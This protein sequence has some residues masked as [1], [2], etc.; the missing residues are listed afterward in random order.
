LAPKWISNRRLCAGII[1]QAIGG[2][3]AGGGVGVG[4]RDTQALVAP[5]RRLARC[6]SCARNGFCRNNEVGAAGGAGRRHFTVVDATV[7][8]G[9]RAGV[10]TKLAVPFWLGPGY[11]RAPQVAMDEGWIYGRWLLPSLLALTLWFL[12]RQTVLIAAAGIFVS[13]LLPVSGIIPFQFQNIS[14][15]ADRSLYLSMLGPALAFASFLSRQRKKIVT[16]GCGLILLS[17]GVYSSFQAKV[18]HD[19]VSLWRYALSIG[20]TSI[21]IYNN[22]TVALIERSEIEPAIG[23]LD[24]A[25]QMKPD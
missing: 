8:R 7:D 3:G 17:M 23:L 1:G 19:S 13:A 6:M 10:L 4:L 21:M 18:W 5:E 20:Q 15:V 2:G 16:I 14:T 22:L 9:G 24:Q 12:R 11:G 25:V